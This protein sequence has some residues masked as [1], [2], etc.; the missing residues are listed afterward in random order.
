MML[1]ILQLFEKVEKV[2]KGI[3]SSIDDTRGKS[4]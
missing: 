4:N 2:K 3:F 1:L